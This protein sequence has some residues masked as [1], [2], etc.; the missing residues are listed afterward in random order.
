MKILTPVIV[1]CSLSLSTTDGLLC[2]RLSI[3]IR[4]LYA[5]IFA[6]MTGLATVEPSDSCRAQPTLVDPSCRIFEFFAAKSR[7]SRHA[8]GRSNTQSLSNCLQ[9]AMS[10]HTRAVLEF[11]SSSSCRLIVR[12]VW[13]FRCQRLRIR[14]FVTLHC[15]GCSYV[16][17]FTGRMRAKPL[18]LARIFYRLTSV[19]S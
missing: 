1:A 14:G 8:G 9:H 16:P 5:A 3:L 15:M 18:R 10:L 13:L 12:K 2:F 11:S 7:P 19:N 17:A 4:Q 6:G